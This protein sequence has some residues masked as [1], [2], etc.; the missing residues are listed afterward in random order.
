MRSLELPHAT[1]FPARLRHRRSGAR[2]DAHI[3]VNV[4][5]IIISMTYE[6]SKRGQ[7]RGQKAGYAPRGTYDM[8]FV[9]C[10]VY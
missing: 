2:G 9:E 4:G 3:V 7:A 10:P 8:N 6:E 1:R 5:Q